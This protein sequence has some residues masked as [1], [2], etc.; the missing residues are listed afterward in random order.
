MSL[1][2]GVKES[3]HKDVRYGKE[4]RTADNSTGL[5]ATSAWVMAGDYLLLDTDANT[6][7]S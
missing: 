7:R 1:E 3:F 2:M 6:I 4:N 5:S